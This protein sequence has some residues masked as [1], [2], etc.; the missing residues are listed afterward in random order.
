MNS[1]ERH[2]YNSHQRVFHEGDSAREWFKKR[3][4]ILFAK[5]QI[6][7]DDEREDTLEDF[8]AKTGIA[9]K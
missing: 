1:A 8:L 5:I 9:K 6:A 2:I 4:P 3:N 7:L